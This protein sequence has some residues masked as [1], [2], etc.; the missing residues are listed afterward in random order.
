MASKN[1]TFDSDFNNEEAVTLVAQTNCKK[2][3][4]QALRVYQPF[5]LS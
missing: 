2:K 1:S 4:S 3:N 5:P